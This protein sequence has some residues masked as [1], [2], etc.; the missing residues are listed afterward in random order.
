MNKNKY[1]IILCFFTYLINAQEETSLN[2]SK[3]GNSI[4][5][6]YDNKFLSRPESVWSVIRSNK[7]KKVYFGT[8]SG[9]L[10]YDGNNINNIEIN[11]E[12]ENQIRTSYTRTLLQDNDNVIYAAGNGFFGKIENDVFG[13]TTYNSL[14][15]KLPD[16]I[17]SLNQVFWGGV[18]KENSIYLY[19]RDLIFKWDG[20][21]FDKI[22]EITERSQGVDSYGTIQTLI[23]V[24]DRIFTRIWGIGL[25]ELKNN[26]F[27]FVQ[28][29]EIFSD[30]KI[31]SMVHLKDGHIAIFSGTLGAYLLKEKG[32]IEKIKNNK[33]DNWIKKKNIYGLSEL[34]KLSNGQIP[35][36]SFEGGVLILNEQLE[37]VDLIDQSDGLLS[38]TITSIFVDKNDDIFVTSL[39]SASKVK[40]SNSITSFDQSTGVKGLVQTIKKFDD[41]LYFSTTE[42]VF[43]IRVNQDPK[44]N[45]EVIDLEI[46]DIP[47]DFISFNGKIISSNNLNLIEING[48]KKQVLSNDR[49][50]ESP[51][52]SLLNKNLLILAHP[53]DGVVFYKKLNN[54]SF[55]KIK[56]TKIRNQIGV[57]GIREVEKGKLFV[58]SINGE[59]SFLGTYDTRGNIY[60]SRLLTP[61]NDRIFKS[62]EFP[63]EALFNSEIEEDYFIPHDLN[64]FKTSIGHLIF[65]DELNLYTFN[66]KS[67]LEETEE[68]LLRIFEKNLLNFDEI[69]RYI[70]LMGRK[71][72]T[73][74]S[75]LTNNNWFLSASGLLEVNFQ[76][77]GNYRIINDYPLASI[78]VNELSGSILSDQFNGQDLIW[79]GSKDSRLISFLPEKYF[80]E[81][82]IEIEPLINS[83][84]FN[85]EYAPLNKKEFSY[86]NSRNVKINF[87]FPSLEKVE[88]NLFRYRLVGLD[89]DWSSW[90]KI[91]ESSF[92]NLFE[93]SYTFELQALDTNLIESEVIQFDFTINSPWYR[94]YIAYFF[95]LIFGSVLVWFFGKYQTKKSLG[96]AENERREK[97]L[98]EAKKIQESMLPK[99]FPKL[100]GFDVSAG[101]ITS[102]EVGGDYYDFFEE[103]DKTVY[104]I[105]GDATGHGIA[106][107]MMVS[108]IKSALNGIPFMPI[109]QILEKLNSIV[110]KI[111]LGRLRMSLN[112]AKIS[113]I[114]DEI[115]LTSAAMPP[116]Y[117]YKSQTNKCEEIMIEGLPLGGLKNEKFAINTLEFSKGD[118]LVMMSDGLAEAANENDEM[119]DYPRIKSLIEE[120][121]MK[122]PEEIKNVFFE[123]LNEWL[124]GGIPE[125]DVTLVIVKKVA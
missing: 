46:N 18:S 22:W 12:I 123:D 69:S 53:M 111:N 80:N 36:I 11:G 68:N 39:L 58:E 62:I 27:V 114:S 81:Q 35:L 95:Y 75:P 71:Q 24:N 37:I 42:D 119:F 121:C 6:N 40:L 90:S 120:N 78:N 25:F 79:L 118:V 55:K 88:E 49:L 16:S 107:G 57:L 106:A 92:T 8:Y 91:T 82:K 17:N 2:S 59:G 54:G 4:I 77:G 61:E 21:S 96:K 1:L 85:G 108:I 10:E 83:I 31:Q 19:S 84:L 73:S 33:L 34:N 97:D 116:V 48:N 14:M 86:S 3:L 23:K 93:G 74:I 99:V 9:I 28:N 30:H 102:T 52:Q 45:N 98:E 13:K 94:A 87:S 104:V 26:V 122:S 38:N 117:I 112:I 89:D 70:I 56:S 101:L 72:F 124:K 29:S 103:D 41:G 63:K 51:T 66:S 20:S 105:C 5:E 65:D 32:L 43:K 64:I 67:E 50:F 115:D 7:S 125:D 44:L 15:E 110:K 60:F 76:E 100:K 109:N 47:K 113:T